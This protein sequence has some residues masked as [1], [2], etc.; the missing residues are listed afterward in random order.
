M[1]TENGV[2]AEYVRAALAA[3]RHVC[4]EYPLCVSVE[5]GEELIKCA[6]ARNLVLHVEHIE[7]MAAAH[8]NSELRNRIHSAAGMGVRLLRVDVRFTGSPLSKA[9]GHPAW[10]GLARMSRTWDLLGELV[11]ES[12][13]FE[14][15]PCVRPDDDTIEFC[16]AAVLR[17]CAGGD[18]LVHWTEA[19]RKGSPRSTSVVLHFD[20]GSAVSSEDVAAA[21]AAA[22]GAGA[23]AAPEPPSKGL[24]ERDLEIFLRKIA[25]LQPQVPPGADDG[26]YDAL[27]HADLARELQWLRLAEAVAAL[28]PHV[29]FV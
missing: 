18:V 5:E 9:W 6:K 1:C 23:G 16:F 11:A 4:V 10:S 19:R 24:F 22:A 15:P 20:D 28:A 17:A 21:A 13:A 25:R 8:V 2:H 29:A 12:A 26:S 27:V 14:T 7:L 3:G